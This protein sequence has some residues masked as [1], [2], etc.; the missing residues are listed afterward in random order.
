[1]VCI[2]FPGL[3]INKIIVFGI[4]PSIFIAIFQ[5]MFIAMEVTLLFIRGKLGDP[6]VNCLLLMRFFLPFGC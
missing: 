1:V 5:P 4:G 6:S 2:S 3:V